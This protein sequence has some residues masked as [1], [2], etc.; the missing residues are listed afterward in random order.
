MEGLGSLFPEAILGLPLIYS[1]VILLLVDCS[2]F[3][4]HLCFSISFILT[5]GGDKGKGKGKGVRKREEL[6]DATLIMLFI[7]GRKEG[8]K[9]GMR[10]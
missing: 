1:F 5:T 7:N 8:R 3:S 6:G 2:C 9:G 4:C 10:K